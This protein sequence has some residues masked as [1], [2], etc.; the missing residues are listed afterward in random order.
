M[1]VGKEEI[2]GLLAAVELYLR[3]DHAA[4]LA[5]FEA[6]VRRW[7]EAFDGRPGVSDRRDFPNEAG[8]PVPRALIAF[9]PAVTGLTGAEIRHRLWEGDPAIAVAAA[10]TTGICL[11]PDTLDGADARTIV[12]RLNQILLGAV[13]DE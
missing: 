8:Q 12:D 6:T 1:K 7:V 2:A 10:G 13:V 4:R 11:T 9:D 3:Q 5:G